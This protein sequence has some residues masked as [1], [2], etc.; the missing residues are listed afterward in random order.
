MEEILNSDT[1]QQKVFTALQKRILLRKRQAAFHPNAS[2]TILDLG[3]DLF[4]LVRETE[5][6]KI[7]VI[8]N[9]TPEVKTF[10]SPEELTFDLISNTKIES[11]KLQPYQCLWLT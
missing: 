9:L 5:G 10:R 7:T 3:K 4:V 2:Q 8:A 11:N 1:P 6:Q